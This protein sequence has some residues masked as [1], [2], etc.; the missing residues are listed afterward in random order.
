MC[1]KL[2]ACLC[3]LVVVVGIGCKGRKTEMPTN[4]T[5]PPAV[6]AVDVIGPRGKGPAKTPE[7]A[8]PEG[9]AKVQ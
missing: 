9:A 6:D 4:P 1:K 2:A 8:A 7:K 3:A 5:K